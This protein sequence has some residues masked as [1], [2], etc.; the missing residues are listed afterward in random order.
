MSQLL[1]FKPNI[2]PCYMILHFAYELA[3]FF[4]ARYAFAYDDGCFYYALSERYPFNYLSIE[5]QES[6][7]TTLEDWIKNKFKA[8]DIRPSLYQGET[9]Y[10]RMWYPAPY[11]PPV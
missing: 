7:Y 10:K 8:T 11:L 4:N 2:T 1:V 6:N 5:E 3:D 9:V